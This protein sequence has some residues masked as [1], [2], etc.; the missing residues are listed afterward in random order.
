MLLSLIFETV[1]ALSFICKVSIESAIILA[2]EIVFAEIFSP[3]IIELGI[4]FADKKLTANL[5]L[6]IL[7]S[8]YLE[9]V[10][11]PSSILAA[12]TELL[13]IFMV[14]TAFVS[15]LA[16]ETLLL[17]ILSTLTEPAASFDPVILPSDMCAVVIA[18]RFIG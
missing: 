4:W 17:T 13:S 10:I 6:V 14:V 18:L 16:D 7:P 5:L 8:A 3:V 15:N 11:L 2:N 9:L 12:V 1:I